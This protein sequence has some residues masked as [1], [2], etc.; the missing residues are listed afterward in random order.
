MSSAGSHG[1]GAAADSEYQNYYCHRC[2]RTVALPTAAFEIVCPVCHDGFL[3]EVES[4]NP[5]PSPNTFSYDSSGNPVL[6]QPFGP[7]FFFSSSS[8]SPAPASLDLR[9][10]ADLADLLGP[11][12]FV[13]RSGP[14]GPTSA[15]SAVPFNPMIF[16]QDYLQ[17]LMSGGANIQVVVEGGPGGGIGNLGDYFIGPG[18]EQLIQQLT[19]NDPNRYGT[20]PAAKSVVANLP[21]IKISLEL[22]ASDEAQCSVCMDTFEMGNEAKQMPC[23]HIFHK[24]CI[25]PW[26]ELHN[27]CPVCRYELPTD[28][29][30]YEQRRGTPAVPSPRTTAGT[31]DSSGVGAA[32]GA[33]TEGDSGSPRMIERRFRI[34]LPWPF[35][36][37]EAQ[38]EGS[39]AGSG[40]NDG[41]N[42]TNP[43]PDRQEDGR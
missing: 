4:P 33:F 41:N 36:M 17:Q 15:T 3:E 43:H 26:L 35:R 2:Q 23:K 39:N 31:R 21:D 40:G 22:L 8:S 38:A 27:S 6:L 14:G 28:D 10:P 19:E 18:L 11:D 13:S 16:L 29:L 32:A 1:G 12:L 7:S 25:L 34:S 9:N 42:S 20:P 24:N 37:F 5:S 30:D